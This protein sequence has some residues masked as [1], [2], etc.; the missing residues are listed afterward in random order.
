[1]ERNHTAF[2]DGTLVVQ[3]LKNSFVYNLLFMELE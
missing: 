1:M 3:R 2:K